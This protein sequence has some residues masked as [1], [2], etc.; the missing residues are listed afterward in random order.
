M[1][2]VC[3]GSSADEPLPWTGY[4]GYLLEHTHTTGMIVAGGG[5][6]VGM[7][8]TPVCVRLIATAPPHRRAA[9]PGRDGKCEVVAKGH[10]DEVQE[11][12]RGGTKLTGEA[13]WACWIVAMVACRHVWWCLERWG[14]WHTVQSSC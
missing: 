9:T 5:R 3:W 12:K 8:S 1:P 6:F 4:A 10:L 2:A 11:L 13:E 14:G 7:L